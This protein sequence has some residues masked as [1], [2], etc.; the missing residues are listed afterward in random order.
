MAAQADKQDK[1]VVRLSEELTEQQKQ[2]ELEMF[3]TI[4]EKCPWRD[5]EANKC[6]E[7][8]VEGCAVWHFISTIAFS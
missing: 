4:A 2:R 5:A 1:Q 7:C 3:K 6:T 8:K